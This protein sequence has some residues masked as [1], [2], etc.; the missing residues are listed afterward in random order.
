MPSVV[1]GVSMAIIEAAS[2]SLPV[3]ISDQVGNH[4]EIAEDNSGI[5]V[6][7]TKNGVINGIN[8]ILTNKS[9]IENMAE[10]A[11]DS[12]LRRYDI[13]LI[14]KKMLE[15]YKKVRSDS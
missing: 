6:P 2:F 3:I 13:N 8:A 10:R 14:C 7:A 12:V 4:R 15:Y 1:E 5:V 9:L 11:Y